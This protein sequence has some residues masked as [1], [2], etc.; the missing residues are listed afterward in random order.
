MRKKKEKLFQIRWPRK[1]PP[2]RWRSEAVWAGAQR[3]LAGWV[4]VS[5]GARRQRL[6]KAGQGGRTVVSREG[7]MGRGERRLAREGQGSRP[8]G[9]GLLQLGS[10]AASPSFRGH[11]SEQSFVEGRPDW[12]TL[13]VPDEF[14]F[15]TQAP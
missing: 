6:W 8:P 10:P 12:R 1:T 9:E 5:H 11:V 4:G 2:K 13:F 3:R 7:G 15:F 14:P